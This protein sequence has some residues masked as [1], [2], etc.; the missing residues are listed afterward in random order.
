MPGQAKLESGRLGPS[1]HAPG[2]LSGAWEH[3]Q[4]SRSPLVGMDILDPIVKGRRHCIHCTI[5][6]ELFGH[7]AVTFKFCAPESV[8]ELGLLVGRHVVG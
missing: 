5:F 1:I 3:E 7:L 6:H 8:A 2:E 4:G